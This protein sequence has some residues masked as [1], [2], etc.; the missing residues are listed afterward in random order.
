M[1]FLAR[2]FFRRTSIIGRIADIAMIGGFLVR[3]AQRRGLIDDA[4][5]NRAGLANVARG[6]TPSAGEMVVVAGAAMRFARRM[7]SRRRLRR[8]ARLSR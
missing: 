3:F 4:T 7:L 5:L 6:E 8:L 1:R 2:R